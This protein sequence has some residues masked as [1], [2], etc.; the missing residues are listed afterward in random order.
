MS[1]SDAPTVLA[2]RKGEC[3]FLQLA[4]PGQPVENAGVLLVDPAE[5]R[6]YL[7]LRRDWE[8]ISDPDD[9]E[10]LEALEDDLALKAREMGA[11]QCLRYLEDTLSNTVRVT[12]REAV[13]AANFDSRVKRLYREHI[14][15]AVLPFQTHLPV[16]SLRAAAGR[17]GGEMEVEP[18]GYEEI[19]EDMRLTDDMFV[20]HVTGR[21]MEPKI[22]D[23]SLCLFRWG[24]AGSR[25]GRLVLVENFGLS[26]NQGRY[27][28]KRYRSEKR[29]SEEGWEHARI[30]LEPLNPEFEPWE[31]GPG[32][33]RVVAE[34]LRVVE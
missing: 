12:E 7:K 6:L 26:E 24:V 19:L 27:T 22:S 10:V 11:Q 14:Q 29:Q 8:H 32:D 21:S 18:E 1:L 13:Q 34:F 31:L 3:L 23:G 5:D 28:I 16:Y 2:V 9:A 33:F 17:F 4:L 30:V 20:A 25:Q 15:P